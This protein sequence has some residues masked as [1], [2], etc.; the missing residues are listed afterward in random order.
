VA[1][2]RALNIYEKH[3]RSVNSSM[4]KK[5]HIEQFV[6]IDKLELDFQS[7]LTILTGETGAGKSIILGALGIILGGPS[8]PSSI[9]QGAEQSLF[10]AL[11]LP[12]AGHPV[13]KFLV[14]H[15]LAAPSDREFLIHRTV[16]REGTDDILLNG[17]TV[18]LDFLQKVGTFLL[19]IHGQF[20]N[21]SLLDPVNQMTWLDLSGAF[22][23]E[24]FK[25]VADALHDV[26]RYAKELEEERTFFANHKGQLGK[27]ESLVKRF[28]E[29][30]IAEGSIEAVEEEYARLLTA[31]ETCEAFQAILAQF[32]SSNGVLG[33]LKGTT[34][35]L[36]RQQNMEVDKVADLAEYLSASLENAHAAVAEIRRLSPQYEIDTEPLHRCEE[37]LGVLD[38]ISRENK[39]PVEDLYEFYKDTCIKLDRIRNGAE[40]IAQLGD[41]LIQAKN[42]YRHHAHILTEMRIVAGKALSEAITAEF[43][44]LK[45]M[46]AE[47]E[48]VV[49]EKPEIP[50]T[51]LG[52]NN[53]IFTARMNPGMPFSPIAETASGGEM[54][55]MILAL[56][57]I[58]QRVQITPT[59]VFDEVDTGI[60]GPAAA[61]VGERLSQLAE[62][63]QVLVI[64]HSPQVASRGDQH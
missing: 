44:P 58:L 61:A 52:F 14:E 11:F 20:A 48:V 59:L 27:I 46:K 40:R 16:K 37:I 5:L 36:A 30:E 32:V 29:I 39:I 15:A 22:P 23:P 2:R 6:I 50:W 8:Y 3:S 17:K 43:P 63:T 33:A 34:Q 60:G 51:E 18:D 56:K 26:N 9:R 53:V 1:F 49:E 62:S 25:N 24:I 21:Q 45:L 4:L 55:R 54:A 31:R 7:G 41:L 38:A 57:V 19:E 13:L 12:P 47:F 42:A 28:D 64:T 35:I 10:E